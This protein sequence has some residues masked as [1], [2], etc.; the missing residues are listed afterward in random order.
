VNVAEPCRRDRRIRTSSSAWARRKGSEVAV[1][2]VVHVLE[3]IAIRIMLSTGLIG[4]TSD[5]IASWAKKKAV[6]KQRSL[7]PEVDL[8]MLTSDCS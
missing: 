5:W 7:D 4:K 6:Q 2:H 8:K 3:R 1:L